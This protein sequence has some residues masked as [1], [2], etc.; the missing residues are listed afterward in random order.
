LLLIVHK[1]IIGQS[2]Y[3]IIINIKNK[4]LKKIGLLIFVLGFCLVGASHANAALTLGAL[5]AASDGAL[6]ITTAVASAGNLFT[7]TTTGA[8][9]IG[10]SQTTGALTIGGAQTTGTIN[11]RSGNPNRSSGYLRRNNCREYSIR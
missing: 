2:N 10:T 11:R 6:T 1:C 4:M 3:K 8:I 9:N 5:T 7:T